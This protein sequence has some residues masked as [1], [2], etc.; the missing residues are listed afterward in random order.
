MEFVR[1]SRGKV[2]G[3]TG[4]IFALVDEVGKK[5][6]FTYVVQPPADG[7]WGAK[8]GGQ[9]NGMIRQVVLHNPANSIV[10]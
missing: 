5:L 1:D 10:Y 4:L 8:E 2:V 3:Y 9:W 6:N 7:L